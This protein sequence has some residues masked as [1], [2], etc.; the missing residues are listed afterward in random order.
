M[1]RAPHGDQLYP[2]WAS[3]MAYAIR[4]AEIE[5]DDHRVS[6]FEPCE[7]TEDVFKFTKEQLEDPWGMEVPGDYKVDWDKCTSVSSQMKRI[8]ATTMY[9]TYAR[10]GDGKSPPSPPSSSS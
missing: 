9:D 4:F 5:A 1:G 10:G 6:L 2:A 7:N 8:S 3:G